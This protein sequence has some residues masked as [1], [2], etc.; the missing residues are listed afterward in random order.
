MHKEDSAKL[1]LFSLTTQKKC[2]KSNF[3]TGLV[4]NLI[5]T[6]HS[7]HNIKLKNSNSYCQDSE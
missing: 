3:M 6:K 1:K 2:M 7:A 4:K 5:Y